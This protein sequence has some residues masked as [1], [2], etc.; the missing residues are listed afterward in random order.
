VNSKRIKGSIAFILSL[1]ILAGSLVSC[2]GESGIYAV[3]KAPYPAN[4]RYIQKLESEGSRAFG[5]ETI[6]RFLT[7]AQDQNRV[8]S[9]INLYVAMAM[10]AETT[11][12]K[13]R[14]EILDLLG[15]D[16]IESLR[17]TVNDILNKCYIDSKYAKSVI[18]DSV[19]L[20]DSVEYKREV[21]DI[22]AENYYSST[23][24]GSFG[25]KGYDKA[26]RD[27]VNE[28]TEGYLKD[29][30]SEM[31]HNSDNVL[32]LLSTVFLKVQWAEKF[33][34]GS[35]SKQT[36]HSPG[37]DVEADFMHA[38]SMPG[39]GY[40]AGSFVAV[41]LPLEY[42]MKMYL[43]L[44]DEGVSI[45]EMLQSEQAQSFI[46]DPSASEI[47]QS[48]TL[49]IS[50]PKFDVSSKTDLIPG[51]KDLGVTE[52]FGSSADF[53]P[54]T[55]LD[56]LYVSKIE[57]SARVM[58]DE[59]GLKAVSYVEIVADDESEMLVDGHMRIVLDR[60]FVFVVT[61]AYSD[62][63]QLFAGVVNNP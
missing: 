47:A 28:N 50:L 13:T 4:T 29:Q 62:S 41:G 37:G 20:D 57:N 8:Y 59:D 12:G 42:G 10:L 54:L 19:W 63:I 58:V 3:V 60:P 22:L 23:F 46:S 17:G 15:A 21:L 40:E 18:A 52:C 7:G 49:D 14:A 35:T 61:G 39:A 43:L 34:S 11:S 6:V 2:G 31:E 26:M 1:I 32:V 45:D 51:L 25:D 48:V 36:F 27:W 38:D 16:S 44:P 30:V 33:S 24:S 5:T 9:P 56:D 53:T 55:D